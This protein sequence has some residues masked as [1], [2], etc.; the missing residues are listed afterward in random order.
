[1]AEPSDRTGPWIAAA[2]LCRE[3]QQQ[4]G[5][6]V[7]DVLG[8]FQEI[9]VEIG[10]IIPAR[11]PAQLFISLLRGQ[12]EGNHEITIDAHLPNG[13][14]Q[15]VGQIALYFDPQVIGNDVVAEIAVPT[16]QAGVIWF[17]I[18]LDSQIVTR[19]AVRIQH[20]VGERNVP[21]N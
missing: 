1:M 3:V 2:L 10:D 7:R 19:I 8:I 20:H 16:D 15:I 12:A 17:D 4:P 13:D 5:G 18:L 6:A 21:L 9:I 11:E 14:K